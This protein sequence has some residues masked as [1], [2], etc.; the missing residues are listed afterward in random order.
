MFPVL[1]PFFRWIDSTWLSHE[2]RDSTWQFAIFEMI[3]LIGLTMLLGSL[4]VL[5][6]RL[7]GFG[8][9]RQ[10]TADLSRD[11]RGWLTSGLWLILLTGVLLFFGEPMKLYAN[12]S[13]HVKMLLLFLAIVFQF[14]LF[15]RIA[16]GKE[17]SPGVNKF[18]GALSLFLWF[19]VGL[20]GR[21][22]GFL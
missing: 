5:D 13:F 18:A 9:K 19:G 3:H 4:M 17:F 20:A 7:F 22:I 2:I 16:N 10:R 15:N 14:T 11:L 1:L 21:G 12:A 6:L 8:I